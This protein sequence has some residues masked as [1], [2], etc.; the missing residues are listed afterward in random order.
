MDIYIHLYNKHNLRQLLQQVIWC[1]E[2][3]NEGEKP[4]VEIILSEHAM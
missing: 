3:G 4:G 1:R 2:E